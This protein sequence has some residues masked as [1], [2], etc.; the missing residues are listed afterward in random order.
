F[1]PILVDKLDENSIHEWYSNL[2]N[3]GLLEEAVPRSTLSSTQLPI[4]HLKL[5][6][7]QQVNLNSPGAP[8]FEINLAV[9]SDLTWQAGDIARLHIENTVREY[10]IASV[11][12]EQSLK[13]LVREQK[14]PTGELGLG[15]G[16]LCHH[17]D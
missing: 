1:A 12:Q 15:S 16:W 6:G 17:A 13:L 10:S 5:T 2:L 8:L 14:H 3:K 7:R 9:P 4:Q 11:P